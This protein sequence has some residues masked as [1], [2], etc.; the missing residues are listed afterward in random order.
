MPRLVLFDIDGTLISCDGSGRR[1][2][3]DALEER[4]GRPRLSAGV[5][6]QGRMD[7]DIVD[8]I[9]ERAGGNGSERDWL[10]ERYVELLEQELVENPPH[11]LP[12]VHALLDPLEQE[13]VVT[14]GLVTGN[15]PQGAR[16]KLLA[17]GLWDHFEFG[18]FA[19]EAPTRGELVSLAMQRAGELRG[20]AFASD[21]VFFV[22]DTG[23]DVAAARLAGTVPVA[24]ATGGQS[25]EDLAA[26]EPTVLF[27]SLESVDRFLEVVL[28]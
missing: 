25:Y 2:L 15:V 24:V 28:S 1:S 12:G 14:L 21:Y 9:I 19:G 10:L 13:Q 4:F 3:D 22:G 23:N 18:C 5:G 11:V 20:E 26:L 8:E 17:A 7:P 6:F 16:L 27:E